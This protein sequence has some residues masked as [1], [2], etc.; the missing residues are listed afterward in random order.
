MRL[1]TFGQMQ[2]EHGTVR[3][4]SY[5]L[6]LACALGLSGSAYVLQAGGSSAVRA[7]SPAQLERPFVPAGEPIDSEMVWIV[8]FHGDPEMAVGIPFDE[9]G[10]AAP[11][12][13][14]MP[15]PAVTPEVIPPIRGLRV[16]MR[17]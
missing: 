8:P 17:P 15:D 16:G 1:G 6:G 10:M 5:V 11:G 3:R 7:G 13:A 2:I 12:A 14:A 9:P 4:W